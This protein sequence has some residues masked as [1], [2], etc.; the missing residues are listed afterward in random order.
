MS[1]FYVSL[2]TATCRVNPNLSGQQLVGKLAQLMG[3]RSW[4]HLLAKLV[5]EPERPERLCRW[6]TCPQVKDPSF[7]QAL[8]LRTP[9]LQEDLTR[10]CRIWPPTYIAAHYQVSRHWIQTALLIYGIP[11]NTAKHPKVKPAQES[12][13]L[14]LPPQE[15]TRRLDRAF[16]LFHSVTAAAISLGV[17]PEFFKQRA[18]ALRLHEPT[19]TLKQPAPQHLA[20]T[21]LPRTNRRR[22]NPEDLEH[23]RQM[24]DQYG[25]VHAYCQATGVQ[26]Q[27]A[28]HWAR[29]A[30]WQGLRKTH[31]QSLTDLTQ[32]VKEIHAQEQDDHT[33]YWWVSVLYPQLDTQTLWYQKVT[34]Q[35]LKAAGL[36]PV[37][38]G[39]ANWVWVS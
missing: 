6:Q 33:V 10:L 24:F 20:P 30:E 9:E 39:Y 15:Q 12:V 25:S 2:M 8:R 27:R 19:P 3:E 35:A 38:K 1:Q 26:P 13:L 14:L 11:A 21:E 36:R 5:D 31:M 28:H 4:V 18:W 22:L 29:R 17:T 7:V 32:K 16:Q 23:V 34:R 37:C